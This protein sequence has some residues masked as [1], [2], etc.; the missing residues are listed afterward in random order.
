[1]SQ[2]GQN[3]DNLIFWLVWP[4]KLHYEPQFQLSRNNSLDNNKTVDVKCH[5]L[6]IKVN[7]LQSPFLLVKGPSF[8][9]S[10][11]QSKAAAETTLHVHVHITG[12]CQTTDN[13]PKDG[14]EFQTSL[15][16]FKQ[17][18]PLLVISHSKSKLKAFI[19]GSCTFSDWNVELSNLTI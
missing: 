10:T 1:M 2:K 8:Q 15:Y 13:C 3:K 9:I 6:K 7:S 19:R 11:N 17:P 12:L 16:S 4:V 5:L 14:I 18:S